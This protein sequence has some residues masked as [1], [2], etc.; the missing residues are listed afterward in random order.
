METLDSGDT[1]PRHQRPK[2]Q[3]ALEFAR[4][5]NWTL[6]PSTG[7]AFGLLRC[8]RPGHPCKI[9]VFSTSGANDGS[10]TANHIRSLVNKCSKLEKTENSN[11]SS[12]GILRA[13]IDIEADV[14]K[15]THLVAAAERLVKREEHE[16]QFEA[17]L[18]VDDLQV[19]LDN[20]DAATVAEADA[21]GHAAAAGGHPTDPWPPAEGRQ[22]LITEARDLHKRC[23][24]EVVGRCPSLAAELDA[25]E[26]RIAADPMNK[27]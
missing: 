4:S 14:A 11:D 26:V 7:H 5:A 12:A 1:W 27:R 22:R 15:L 18:A 2:A 16:R 10:D 13:C 23:A 24:N 17:A 6:R 19:A 25:L 8:G 21:L 20:E 3:E 9:S